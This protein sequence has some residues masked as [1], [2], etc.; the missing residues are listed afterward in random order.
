MKI[1]KIA[2]WSV[3]AIMATSCAE[4]SLF[5]GYEQTETGFY[6]MITKADEPGKTVGVDDILTLDMS[7]GTDDT[8]LFDSRLMPNPTQLRLG[9]PAYSGDVME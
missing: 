5:P 8:I 9:A 4:E 3:I 2:I 7:Y 1:N 6:H